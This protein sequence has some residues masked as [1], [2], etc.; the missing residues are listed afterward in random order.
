MNKSNVDFNR[1]L[2]LRIWN[3]QTLLEIAGCDKVVTPTHWQRS[4]FPPEIRSN[5]SVL[6][7]GINQK[8]LRSIRLNSSARASFLQHINNSVLNWSPT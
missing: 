3:S 7:E 8:F 6:H 1:R 5:I 2:R 4:Q